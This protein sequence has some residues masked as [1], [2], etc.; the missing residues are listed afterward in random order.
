MKTM[1]ALALIGSLLAIAGVAHAQT[2]HPPEPVLIVEDNLISHEYPSLAR[3]IAP[4]G[5]TIEVFFD[6]S[7]SWDRDGDALQFVW[8]EFD[9]GFKPF[10]YTERASR[11]FRS[12]DWYYMGLMVSDGSVSVL[13]RFELYITTPAGAVES[14]IDAL[15]DDAQPGKPKQSLLGPLE[16]AVASFQNGDTTRAIHFLEVFQRKARVQTVTTDLE[17]AEDVERILEVLLR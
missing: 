5:S 14:I 6:A 1:L 2:N 8:G 9:D 16:E 11:T 12:G 3:V 15:K 10:A 13:F 7:G 4:P 17:R